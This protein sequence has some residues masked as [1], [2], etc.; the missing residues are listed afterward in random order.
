M[1]KLAV[2]DSIIS[3]MESFLKKNR[4]ADLITTYLFF[5]EKKH[6]LDPVVFMRE[7]KIYQSKDDLIQILESAGKLWRET[8]IKIQIGKPSVN[9]ATQK[10]YI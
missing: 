4:R 9:A 8:E 3:E 2:S 6:R 7:K 5:L 10:I 1:T